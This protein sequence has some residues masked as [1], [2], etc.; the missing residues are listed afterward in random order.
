MLY[1]ILK[2]LHVVSV[3][4][5]LGNIITGVFWKIHGDAQGDLRAREQALAGIIASDRLFTLPGV[6][7]IIVSGTWMALSAHIPLL[8]T[9]WTAAGIWLFLASGLM[10]SLRVQPLQKQLLANVR[11]G[12]AGNWDEATYRAMSRAWAIWGGI[13]TLLPL[14]VIFFMVFKPG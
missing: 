9:L 12:L 13:A 11:A 10:F 5:F 1:L 14:I 4:L 8:S 3:I 7:L 2:S 6:V